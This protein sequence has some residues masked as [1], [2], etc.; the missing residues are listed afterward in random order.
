M[1]AFS[2]K[3]NLWIVWYL[4]WLEK[5]ISTAVGWLVVGVIRFKDFKPTAQFV[6]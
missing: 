4:L 3:V 5:E 6:Q 1:H 2:Q